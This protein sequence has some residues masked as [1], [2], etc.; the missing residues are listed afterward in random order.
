MP[1][2]ASL[3]VTI[4][5]PDIAWEDKS[6]NLAHYTSL[7]GSISG[8][9]EIVVLPEMFATGFSMAPERLAEVLAGDGTEAM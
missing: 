5:Q 6:V 9:K 8:P 4:V 7:I 2:P 1:V 3:L